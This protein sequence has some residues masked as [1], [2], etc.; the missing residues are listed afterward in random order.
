MYTVYRKPYKKKR[1]CWRPS[2]FVTCET[3]K[4]SNKNTLGQQL[5]DKGGPGIERR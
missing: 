3:S 2:D 1:S 5:F 4:L